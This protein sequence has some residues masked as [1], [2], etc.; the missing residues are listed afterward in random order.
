MFIYRPLFKKIKVINTTG[1]PILPIN[2]Y[3]SDSK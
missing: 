3:I 1:N 2:F